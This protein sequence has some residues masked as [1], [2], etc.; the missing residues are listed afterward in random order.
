[1]PKIFKTKINPNWKAVI[2]ALGEQDDLL[3]QL[4]QE[5]K[6]QFFVKTASRPYLDTLGANVEVARPRQVG[7]DDSTMRRFIPVMSYQ[8]KQVKLILDQ[9]LDIFFF[10]ESTSA[11]TQSS[12]FEPFVLKDGWQL[13]YKVDNTNEEVITF[14]TTDFVDISNATANEVA[15]AINRQAEH[16]F[17]VVFDDRVN[18]IKYVRLFTSTVG[19][20]G[21]I[22]ITG[23]QANIG[24]RFVG[25]NDLAGS[26]SDTEWTITKIG[27][28]IT[29]QHTGG[30]SP[31][32]SSVSVGDVVLIDVPDNSGSFT[33]TDINLSSASFSFINLF[34]TAGT[35]DH[36]LYPDSSVNFMTPEKFFVYTKESRAIVWE[37]RPGQIIV[38]MPATPPVVKRSLK[39]SAHLNGWVGQVVDVTN[40][41]TLELANADEWPTSGAFILQP[42]C[43]VQTHYLT[44][45]E[46]SYDSFQFKTRFDIQSFRY[47]Y[48]GKSGN[49]LTGISPSLPN[50]SGIFEVAISSLVRQGTEVTV[51]TTSPHNFREGES[52]RL[53][54]FSSNLSTTGVR[55][56]VSL[57]DT[58][59]DVATKLAVVLN[60]L[61]DFS[62]TSS[63]DT[64][65]ITDAS[66]GAA[67][68][69][70]DVDSGTLITVTQQGTVSLPEIT[71]AIV[72][73]GS[74]YDV[75]GDALR[76]NINSSSGNSYHVWF[77]VIDGVNQQIN[78]GMNDLD[79][80]SAEIVSVL[81]GSSFT[82]QQ[83]GESG[84]ANGGVARVERLGIANEGL[85]YL[86]SANLNT[87]ILGPNV[88]D[89]NA[90]FVLSSL[91]SQT[92]QEIKQ[93][94]N[95][96]TLT[97][98][99][100]NNI[101]NEEGFVIFGF[102]TEAQEGP[103]RYL[104]KPNNSTMQI[105]PAYFFQNTHPV[106]T[107][108]TVIRKRGAH[109][110]STT[111]REYAPYVTDPA[112]AREVLQDLLL[113][114]KSVGVSMEFLIRYPNQLY[115]T[116]D[117]Y[118]S[119]SDLLY[120]VSSED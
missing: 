81:S 44:D 7:M 54:N 108:I 65:E 15:S 5:V 106:G 51:T 50:E 114:V 118:R 2:E 14:S 59:T 10:R 43:E 17:A 30:T 86:T 16:S 117:V 103:V 69:A 71:E 89:S 82:V 29:F 72:L 38:E 61:S 21:S 105:D 102:G 76:F 119:G 87:G 27:D 4:V 90:A 18:K 8:P 75:V 25:F 58:A 83:A 22:Q 31:N 60:S 95:V 56:D 111:G 47:T 20:K 70:S 77:N 104:F 37:T 88:W 1:M 80:F 113:K 12:L 39:G 13:I 73:A 32:L 40:S 94:T 64:V 92:A 11:F 66:N 36:S 85:A 48:T 24:L 93:G 99:S 57:A 115:A 112:I 53:Q 120:P 35:F 9:L 49:Y 100:V 84:Q 74:S 110:I 52:V 46:D 34:G 42:T 6:K 26:G 96:K 101:P 109:T 45:S 55:V 116:L 91:T 98:D 68:D 63:F 3:F 62:A 97:I 23:G 79:S 41:T 28:T 107:A 78:P 33:I 67:T 19:A